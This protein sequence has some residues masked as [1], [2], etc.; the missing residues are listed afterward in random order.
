MF[1]RLMGRAVLTQPHRVVGVHPDARRAHEGGESKGGTH[2]IAE[3]QEGGAERAQTAVN[4][5]AVDDRAHGVLADTE[6]YVAPAR[7][8][9][10]H[11]TTAVDESVGGRLEVCTPADQRRELG[12]DLVDGPTR[13]LSRGY[14]IPD[15]IAEIRNRHRIRIPVVGPS[16][17]EGVVGRERLVAPRLPRSSGIRAPAH[18]FGEEGRDLGRHVEL[19]IR[20]PSH[21]RLG[22]LDLGGA[23]GLAVRIGGVL[24]RRCPMGDVGMTN[25]ERRSI[26]G[27]LCVGDRLVDGPSVVAVDVEGVPAKRA[28]AAGD[29]LCEGD[30]GASADRNLVVVVQVDE[31]AKAEMAGERSG[32]RRDALHQIPVAD[33]TVRAVID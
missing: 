6:P 15:L 16:A 21:G 26:D 8:R 25:D 1:D 19:D 33:E 11:L 14:R 13:R 2:V 29:V 9:G 23:Q 12:R 5:H 3:D 20:G 18:R 7:G 24:Q 32:L 27:A 17:G 10:L 31:T 4:R 28:E 30:V 22:R